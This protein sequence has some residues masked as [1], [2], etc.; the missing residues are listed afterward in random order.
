MKFGYANGYAT[1]KVTSVNATVIEHES[2]YDYTIK[3]L[4]KCSLST[5]S[6]GPGD[7]GGPYYV[8]DNGSYK[9]VG[10]HTGTVS[11]NLYFTPYSS[12]KKYFTVKTSSIRH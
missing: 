3:G 12:F 5:G 7:S 4:I 11:G 9:F 8:L 10:E 1:G 6:S 2:G